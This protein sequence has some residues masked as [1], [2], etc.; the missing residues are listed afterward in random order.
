M[1]GLV[2]ILQVLLEKL[3]QILHSKVDFSDFDPVG[4]DPVDFKLL[5]QD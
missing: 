3:E 2:M 1:N 4:D 5:E